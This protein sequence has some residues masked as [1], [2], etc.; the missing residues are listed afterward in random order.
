MLLSQIKSISEKMKVS[1]IEN[2]YWGRQKVTYYN[3]ID[4]NGRVNKNHVMGWYKTPVGVVKRVYKE[5]STWMAN[6][7]FPS[8]DS[9]AFHQ[10]CPRR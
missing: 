10:K 5:K 4:E 8:V 6:H 7:D 2:I 3:Y 9:G 1:S